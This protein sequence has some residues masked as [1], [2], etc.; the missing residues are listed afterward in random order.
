LDEPGKVST[1]KIKLASGV[2][3]RRVSDRL[4]EEFGYPFRAKDWGELNGNLFYA[5]QLEKVVIAVILT[6]IVVV[7]AFNVVSTL[8]MMIYDKTR[9]VSIL[10]AMGFK[11]SQTFGLFCLIGVGIGVVG[12]VTGIG[13]G[14]G[15]G[16][17]LERTRLI[18][19]P[20]DIYY[21]GYLPV[22]VRWTEITWIGVVAFTITLLA[23]LYPAY[24]VATRSPL[25]GIRYD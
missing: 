25:D 12:T 10:K 16:W 18:R 15:A 22:R 6:I 19:L 9:E 1:F 11:P 13:L 8:M 21:I 17:I 24:K 5:I 7:A 3:S 14:L 2:D 4:T 20:A 23:T